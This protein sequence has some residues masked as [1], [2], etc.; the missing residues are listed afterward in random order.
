MGDLAEVFTAFLRLGLTAFGGPVAHLGYFNTEFVRRRKWL[1]DE[2]FAHIVALA[3]TLPGP[4]SSQVAIIIGLQRAGLAGAAAAWTAFTLPSAILLALFALGIGRA[5][6]FESSGWIHGLLLAAVAVVALAV[7][8]MFRSLC[9]DVPRAAFA[10]A[11]AIAILLLPPHPL[12]QLVLIA[13]GAAFG[14]VALRVP[15]RSPQPLLVPISR[16]VA[17]GCAVA[18][19]A[20]LAGLPP[21]ARAVHGSALAAFAAFY[22]SGALVFGGG[23]VVLPLLDARVVAPGWISAQ[24]FLAGYGAAQAVPGPLFTF[25]SYLGAAMHG[26]VTGAG[27]AAL[28]LFA[29]YLPSFLLIG[30]VLP[31]WN[32]LV[33]NARVLAALRGINA[34][35]VGLLLAAFYSPVGTNAIHAPADAAF[36]LFAFMLLAVGKAPPWSVVALCA[37]AG[38]ILLSRGS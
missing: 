28:A 20:L 38:P 26:P 32:Q 37:L 36:A 31:F 2:T 16:S 22:E 33:A 5:A 12:A 6:G 1:D 18:F 8:Q 10:L 4:A 21:L 14:V 25:A 7:V 27:G 11:A 13:A 17:I 15:A 24:S 23:H 34:A 19:V 29:I 30:A 35:V 3:Q 9:P